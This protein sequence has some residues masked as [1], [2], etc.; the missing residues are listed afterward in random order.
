MLQKKV[1]LIF[2]T[3]GEYIT[4]VIIKMAL[5]HWG[6]KIIGTATTEEN[7]LSMLKPLSPELIIMDI[8]SKIYL[9][10]KNIIE[11]IK[12]MNIPIIFL[13]THEDKYNIELIMNNSAYAI[14][15]KPIDVNEFKS[16]MS[17][18]LRRA[19]LVKENRSNCIYDSGSNKWPEAY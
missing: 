18:D 15:E 3:L 11:E 7:L 6:H 9:H 12:K 17:S 19:P 4:S 13:A 14:V 1:F 2:L 8:T 10:E 5:E 16:V